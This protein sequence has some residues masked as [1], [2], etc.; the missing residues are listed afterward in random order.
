MVPTRVVL[1]P[2]AGPVDSRRRAST[3]SATLDRMTDLKTF[4]TAPLLGPEFP[5]PL[6]RPFTTAQALAVGLTH[7]HLARLVDHGFVRRL[8]KGVFV[9]SQV[10]DSLLLRM[11]ALQ[12]MVPSGCVV[13][14]WTALWLHTG[15]LPPGQHLE[16]PPV[17]L[18]KHAGRGRLNNGLCRS[19]ERGFR[20]E[21][22]VE[23]EGL[24][25]TT[26]LRTAWDLGRLA[27]RDMAI[28]ALDALLRLGDFSDGE[29]VDGVARFRGMRGVV[30][31]RGLAPLASPLAESG[32]ESVL[33]LRWV[34]LSSLPPPVPQVPILDD[35]GREIYYLD[36]GVPELRF[37]CEYDGV[38]YHSTE[39]DREKDR[40]R[41]RWIEHN[42]GW[43]IEPVRKENV[44]GRS[45][46]I[47]RILYE[48]IARARRRL[49]R[50]QPGSEA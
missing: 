25:V 4:L 8:L 37:A 5:L 1:T 31:L 27:H 38:E 7:R 6:D 26:P 12:L 47:E 34:D 40:K 14:D 45:R 41:R 2:G 20:P 29:L 10:P 35:T 49:R 33:R 13:V 32:A 22:L 3:K 39:A 48:G 44:F 17:C 18:F 30:Q 43:I 15:M 19:G 11:R 16:V 36:L 42:R 46:D 24:L 50:D 23:I 28:G 21:D 9:A